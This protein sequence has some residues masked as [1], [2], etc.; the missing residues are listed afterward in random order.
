MVQ[1]ADAGIDYEKTDEFDLFMNTVTKIPKEESKILFQDIDFSKMNFAQNKETG[2]IVLYDPEQQIVIDRVIFEL[3]TSFVRKIHNLQKNCEHGGNKWTNQVLIE[4]AR[5]RQERSASKPYESV[6][7]PYISSLVN[8]PGFKYDHF[9]VWNL[10]IYAFWDSVNRIQ[11]IRK[12][13]Y[14]MMGLYC[15][16]LDSSSVSK[17][18][19]DWLGRY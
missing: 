16:R 17:K 7:S 13:D 14:T 18:D 4:E 19:Y 6:L 5:K 9:S 2:A 3:I 12:A 15:G 11:K 8:Y 1:L 10:P